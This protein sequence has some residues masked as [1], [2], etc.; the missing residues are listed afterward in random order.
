MV[1]SFSPT[2]RMLGSCIFALQKRSRQA[3][4][5]L[6]IKSAAILSMSNSDPHLA[7]W[8]RRRIEQELHNQELV[9]QARQDLQKI[10]EMLVREFNAKKIILFGSLIQGN[11]NQDSDI[12]LA[13]AGISPSDYFH[14]LAAINSVSDRW[15]DLKPLEA[16]DPHFLK[17]VLQ[18]GECLYASDI[19][20]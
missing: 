3:Y 11:F 6:A 7:Y 4:A 13:V 9:K 10:T 19:N 5:I 17:R 18:T 12:D 1:A 20:G 14:I 2:L 8:Q 16:L 15:I